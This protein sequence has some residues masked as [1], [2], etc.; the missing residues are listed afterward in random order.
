VPEGFPGL[1]DRRRDQGPDPVAALVSFCGPPRGRLR[2]ARRDFGFPARARCRSRLAVRQCPSRDEKFSGKLGN[3]K[4]AI[5][6]R[7]AQGAFRYRP[8]RPMQ[9][10]RF[11]EV[12]SSSSPQSAGSGRCAT[13]SGRFSLTRDHPPFCGCG[14]LS[15][16]RLDGTSMLSASLR[17]RLL[18][19]HPAP[20]DLDVAPGIDLPTRK[21]QF[22]LRRVRT[23][24][25]GARI[26]GGRTRRDE[27]RREP[28][29]ARSAVTSPDRSRRRPSSCPRLLPV[30]Q[31]S[32]LATS[33]HL[34]SFVSRWVLMIA[35]AVMPS[36]RPARSNVA[37][38]SSRAARW[39][40][41]MERQASAA[42]TSSAYAVARTSA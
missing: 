12:M 22:V 4:P 23:A 19:G 39:L 37:A 10:G 17:M 6:H 32:S 20:H 24:A 26:E 31:W 21:A 28:P 41:S 18:G 36:I 8:V 5:A 25:R 27:Q 3:Q 14:E 33:R 13:R 7:G 35:A 38:I 1:I 2:A 9:T 42:L 15:A 40:M 16:L 34:P 30:I 29:L 11:G